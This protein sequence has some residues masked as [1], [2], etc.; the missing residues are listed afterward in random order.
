MDHFSTSTFD[1][2]YDAYGDQIFRYFFVR[3]KDR[4]EALDLTQDVFLRLW[5]YLKEHEVEYPKAFLF[6]AAHNAYVNALRSRKRTFSLESL[7][8]EYDFDLATEEHERVGIAYDGAKLMILAEALPED[9][10]DILFLHYVDDLSIGEIAK[11]LRESENTVSV[12]LH[13][14]RKM[15]AKKVKDQ[16]N[17]SDALSL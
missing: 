3:L 1:G 12:R 16:E 10:R 14:A 11:H 4:R 13:R 5:E 6:R 2:Y 15:L 9:Y 7:I 17:Q 8:E